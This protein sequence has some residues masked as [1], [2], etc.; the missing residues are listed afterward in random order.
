MAKYGK[1]SAKGPD[2]TDVLVYWRE[3]EKMH[4]CYISLMVTHSGSS[5]PGAFV[6]NLLASWPDLEKKE[7]LD[8]C[9]VSVSFPNIFYASW[10]N[11]IFNL[12]Y[13]LDYDL[14]Q[15]RWK[16]EGMPF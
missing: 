2:T 1:T 16:Q 5:I 4:E 10:D 3:V 9:G 11:V 15:K 7:C 14:S 6:V 13:R 8:G 12:L